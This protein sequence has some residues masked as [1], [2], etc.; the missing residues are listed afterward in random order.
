M[1]NSKEIIKTLESIKTF[2]VM[3]AQ[4]LKNI[5]LELQKINGGKK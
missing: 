4:L 3:E 5:L 1:D 2:I